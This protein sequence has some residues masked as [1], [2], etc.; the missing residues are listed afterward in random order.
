MEGYHYKFN[1]CNENLR[2]TLWDIKSLLTSLN[3][4][5]DATKAALMDYDFIE[6]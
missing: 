1:L 2:K 6:I 5:N 4:I 3:L